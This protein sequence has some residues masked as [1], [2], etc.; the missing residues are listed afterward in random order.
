MKV[1][2]NSSLSFHERLYDSLDVS[3][4]PIHLS[5]PLE[6]LMRRPLLY[7]RGLIPPACLQSLTRY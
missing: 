3:L 6:E 2:Y 1:F 4:S 5:E 7:I